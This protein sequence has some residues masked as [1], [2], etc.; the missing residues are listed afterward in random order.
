MVLAG[1]E[2]TGNKLTPR[3]GGAEKK[4]RKSHAEARRRGEGKRMGG[5]GGLQSAPE[6]GKS[7][8]RTIEFSSYRTKTEVKRFT[9][10]G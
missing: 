8:H 5:G 1:G 7:S 4:G 2:R 10:G 9:G 3:R 6:G